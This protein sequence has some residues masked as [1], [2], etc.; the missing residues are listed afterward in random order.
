M[1]QPAND[2]PPPA[3]PGFVELRVYFLHELLELPPGDLTP[4]AK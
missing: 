2:N 1:P 4:V 3:P